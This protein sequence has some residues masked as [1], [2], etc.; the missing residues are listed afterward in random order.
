ML[1]DFCA[2]G[3]DNGPAGG[4]GLGAGGCGGAGTGGSG[5]GGV[6]VGGCE[7]VCGSIN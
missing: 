1:F 2:A 4:V 3:A 5:A 7:L 6:C